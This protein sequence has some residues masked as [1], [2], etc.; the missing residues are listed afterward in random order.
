MLTLHMIM[1]QTECSETSAYKVQM[2]GITPKIKIRHCECC[3]FPL[4]EGARNDLKKKN[5]TLNNT[6]NN[7][8]ASTLSL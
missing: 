3:Q 6:G 2:Q 1:E 5:Q 8:V 7:F 4:L